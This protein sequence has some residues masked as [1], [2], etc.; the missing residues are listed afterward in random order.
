MPAPSLAAK[1]GVFLFPGS[2]RLAPGGAPTTEPDWRAGIADWRL[3]HLLPARATFMV[4]ATQNQPAHPLNAIAEP[5][6]IAAAEQR[7]SS[8]ASAR[9]S[10]DGIG[11]SV[12]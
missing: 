3:R 11:D 2:R 10:S 1:E 4:L 8:G 12:A 5:P 6:A 7:A 9:G